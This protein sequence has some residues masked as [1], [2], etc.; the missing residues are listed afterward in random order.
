M[1]PPL[2]ANLPALFVL[3]YLDPGAGSVVVQVL[4]AGIVGAAA[5]TKFYW[6]RIVSLFSRS[7]GK[8]RTD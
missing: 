4:V 8:A 2:L 3:Q 7:A 5:V 1:T 6:K